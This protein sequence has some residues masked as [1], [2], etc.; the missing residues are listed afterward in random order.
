[1]PLPHTLVARASRQGAAANHTKHCMT[2]E[3]RKR[4]RFEHH[5]ELQTSYAVIL[6]EEKEV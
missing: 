4:G 3:I 1:M 6:L 2:V 5:V